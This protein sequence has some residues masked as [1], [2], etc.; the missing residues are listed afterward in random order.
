MVAPKQELLLSR[1][2][3]KA[4]ATPAPPTTPEASG[5]Q[6]RLRVRERR[7][8]AGRYEKRKRKSLGRARIGD[9]QARMGRV[10]IIFYDGLLIVNE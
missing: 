5:A 1:R 10:M 6:A 3:K 7:T 2:V 4:A 8:D 9:A